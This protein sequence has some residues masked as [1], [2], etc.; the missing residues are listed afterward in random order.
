MLVQQQ[1]LPLHNLWMAALALFKMSMCQEYK[2]SSTIHSSSVFMD[3]QGRTHPRN[4]GQRPSTTT[5]QEPA[6][7]NGT[8]TTS[9]PLSSTVGTFRNHV[10]R[11]RCTV[12]E[13]SGVSQWKV[14]NCFM[15]RQRFIRSLTV[16]ECRGRFVS[17]HYEMSNDAIEI[18]LL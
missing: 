9:A 18:M 5:Y 4:L 15:S 7:Q 11:V 13:E 16:H 10:R 6:A 2:Q 14:E 17:R 12:L 3:R 1:V 8:G